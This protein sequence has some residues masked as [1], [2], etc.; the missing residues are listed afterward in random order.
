MAERSTWLSRMFA[1]PRNKPAVPEDERIYAVGD[2]HG[3]A[4]LLEKMLGLIWAD[5]AGPAQNTLVF[6]GDYIDRGPSSQEVI[7]ILA[8]LERPDWTLIKLRG[9]HEQLLLDFL[10]KPDVY[11]VWRTFGGAETL[12]SYGVRPPLFDDDVEYARARD[13]LMSRLPPRHFAFLTALSTSYAAGDYYFAHAGVRPGIAL[14]KQS[15]EDLMWIREDFLLSDRKLE[16]VVV[17]G[18]TPVER[19]AVRPNR[20]GVDTGAYATDCLTAAVFEGESCRFL[21]T[22][23]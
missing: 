6:L 23:G 1:R 15:P 5:A 19:P 12:Q 3:R 8:T 4:D 16:K 18:H 14:D 13:E 21:S 10:S 9:N 22:R 17:H 11:R 20:I 2:I 7:E